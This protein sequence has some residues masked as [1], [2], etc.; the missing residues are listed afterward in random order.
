MEGTTRKE[1]NFARV[2]EGV[3]KSLEQ[4][5]GVLFQS[6]HILQN[7]GGLRELDDMQIVMRTYVSLHNM[8]VEC[9]KENYVGDCGGGSGEDIAGREQLTRS[10]RGLML[11]NGR[12]VFALSTVSAAK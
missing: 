7:P 8:I 9:R 3:R 10:G 11:R 6:F 12:Q 5:F 4:V 1:I 2:R